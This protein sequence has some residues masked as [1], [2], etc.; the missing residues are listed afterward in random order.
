MAT[1]IKSTAL[2]FASI[3]SNL[4]TFLAQKDEFSDYNFEASGLSNI[5]DVL[6]YNTHY[7]GLIA[8]FALNESFLN[9]A[10]LRSSVISLAEGIGYVP[11][12]KTSSFALVNLSINL[13]GVADRPATVSLLSGTTFSST[14]DDVEYTFQT[15][16][17]ISAT[18]NGSGFY[19]FVDANGS[20]KIKIF[21]GTAVTKTFIITQ[22]SENAVYIIP[23]ESMDIQNAVVRV[24]DS[25][26]STDFVTYTNILDANVINIDSTLFI[27]KESPNGFYELS[28]G[29]GT[30]LGR[31]P[32]AGSK[33]TVT[34]LRVAGADAN[35]G[36]LFEPTSQVT[37]GGVGYDLEVTT[38]SRSAGG[39]SKE[40]IDSI[41]KNAPFQ[42]A[43]QNRMVTAVDYSSLVLRNFSS[44]INDIKS[45]G[46]EDNAEPQYGCIFMSIVFN[47]DVSAAIQQVT[48][49]SI[50]DLAKQLSVASFT[51]K[52]ADPI[53]TFVE[54]DVF[55][56]FNQNLT[57]LSETTIKNNVNTA[58]SNYFTTNTG[59]FGQAF[60]RSNLLTLIDD[61]SPAI[62]SS[63]AE[64]KMQQRI[65][66]TLTATQ[67]HVLKFPQSIADP[68]DKFFRVESSVFVR[69]GKTL[70]I[71]NRLNS[72]TLQVVE[73]STQTVIQD[74]VGSYTGDTL[75][76][77]G[78]TVD[79]IPTGQNFIK[80]SVIP[81]NE[82][83]VV[84]TNQYILNYDAS[85]SAAFS[86]ATTAT[87]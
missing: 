73:P 81:A 38:D 46:G 70:R 75:T 11:D 10:Q 24:Y 12:S 39:A 50:Q 72:N 21:E 53:V 65:T 63:R 69:G 64:V 30:T 61:V 52:F 18:D 17:N 14:I 28:F 16:E 56:R 9:T 3:K 15:Q 44:L 20:N 59:K 37:V 84:P 41:R 36:T 19:E 54:T 83:A 26:T 87:N 32:D 31:T 60:R 74:D 48:K 40:T 57:S 23:D 7:N 78:L 35:G 71:E 4:K 77:E 13:N 76:I 47:D 22:N 49:D 58:I 86:V 2:D 6:A 51:L 1:T 79:S 34:Y 25:P 33:A 55:F 5:L 43:T 82:S 67:T 85:N 29:N 68:D 8:N 42:Y 45:W 80:V 66:P 62:L 27:L